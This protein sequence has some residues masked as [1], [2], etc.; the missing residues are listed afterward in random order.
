MSDKCLKYFYDMFYL[1]PVY[2]QDKAEKC[3]IYPRNKNKKK[4]KGFDKI[5]INLVLIG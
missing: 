4:L 5:E 3:L 1:C 2:G